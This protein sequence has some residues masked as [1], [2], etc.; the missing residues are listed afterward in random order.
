MFRRVVL[1]VVVAVGACVLPATAGAVSA[2]IQ[3]GS[4]TQEYHEIELPSVAVDA[5]GT[6]YAAW[7]DLGTNL[8]DYCVLPNGATSCEFSGTLSP[9]NEPGATYNPANYP[10][11]LSGA[12]RTVD[13]A[14]TGNT[15][16]I[17]AT[18]IGP[19]LANDD[20]IYTPTEEWLAPDGTADF[21]HVNGG[22]PVADPNPAWPAT[23]EGYPS[24]FDPSYMT[25][26]VTVP[27]TGYL[28]ELDFSP[29]GPPS[30]Q[31][32]PDISNPPT[33][34]QNTSPPCAF[35]TLEPMSNPD[36]VSNYSQLL[37]RQVASAT[38]G[39]NPGILAEFETVDTTGPFACTGSN[40][41]A[42]QSD[43]YMYGSGLESPTNNYNI[44]PG[45]PD[46]AWKVPATP[47]PND[48]PGHA[49]SV[50]GGPSGLGLLQASIGGGSTMKYLPLDPA[51]GALDE[52]AVTVDPNATANTPDLAQDG[53]GNLYATGFVYQLGAG[54]GGAPLALYYSGDGGKTWQGPG[55]LETNV[56]PGFDRQQTAVGAD[57]KAWMI[58]TTSAPANGQQ[59]DVYALE[60]TAADANNALAAGVPAATSPTV[61]NSTVTLGVSCFT[62]PCTVDASLLQNGA[63]PDKDGRVTGST[64]GSGALTITQHGVQTIHI[65][66]SSAGESALL[67]HRGH[68]PVI[69]SASTAIGPY[70][71]HTSTPVTITT[72]A[73]GPAISGLKLSKKTLSYRD[74]V[75]GA[76]RFV[77]YIRKHRRWVK[78]DT[79]VHYDKAGANVALIK[80]HLAKGNYRIEA[81]PY[82]A[83]KA[84]RTVAISF[85]V[86]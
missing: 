9:V 67:S 22:E 38:S 64:L 26:E 73:Y 77:I 34:S 61:S 68:L 58:I 10:P 14:I 20:G 60:F 66:L 40:G 59:G 80:R 23:A 85:T 84:G 47:I 11:T 12:G 2:P 13:L 69:F 83:G 74:A 32:F 65:P 70:S 75:A 57:G 21:T 43:V 46:S 8:V 17:I 18:V 35:A 62:V 56:Q 71:Q 81:T 24:R 53:A 63:A 55:A 49:F 30:F 3:I 15:V 5:N 54:S 37:E 76:T 28:G 6:A 7:P 82:F 36:P 1:A 50:A 78:L 39:P 19:N 51:T 52:P 25:D 44:S 4:Y 16:S 45:Q 42:D 33:R 79:F 41:G 72:T 29:G 48:C 27:G 31:A 86:R